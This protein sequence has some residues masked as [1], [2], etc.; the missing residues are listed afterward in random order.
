MVSLIY[1]V[2]LVV[3]CL[4][5]VDVMEMDYLLPAHGKDICIEN[6]KALMC[7]F[8][9]F[10]GMYVSQSVDIFLNFF[11]MDM[12]ELFLENLVGLKGPIYGPNWFIF[13]FW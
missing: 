2:R 8:V 9:F 11:S 7:V 12:L 4:L 10:A 5:Y 1:L 3:N 13:L 6:K